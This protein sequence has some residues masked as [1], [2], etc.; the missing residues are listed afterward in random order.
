MGFVCGLAVLLVI[1]SSIWIWSGYI[2]NVIEKDVTEPNDY[3]VIL[4]DEELGF[5]LQRDVVS[6]YD[7]EAMPMFAY[8][9]FG[10]GFKPIDGKD[11]V[12]GDNIIQMP[13]SENWNLYYKEINTFENFHP[14]FIYLGRGNCYD[15]EIQEYVDCFT[16][17]FNYKGFKYKMV[18][19]DN[20][21]KI[22][23]SLPSNN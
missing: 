22:V 15:S 13:R 5:E 4:V 11:L 2:D 21:G 12:L 9:I 16:P 19:D 17:Y 3:V 18:Y 20:E 23:I 10:Y 7:L 6:K 8:D 14:R 1:I